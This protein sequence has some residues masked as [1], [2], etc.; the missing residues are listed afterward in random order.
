[1]I[2]QTLTLKLGKPPLS[3]QTGNTD[4]ALVDLELYSHLPGPLPYL[5]LLIFKHIQHSLEHDRKRASVKV[6]RY[7]PRN[8]LEIIEF[9]SG[10]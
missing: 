6:R 10:K 4:W 5:P 3:G 8:H 7:F 2:S 9:G 1:M